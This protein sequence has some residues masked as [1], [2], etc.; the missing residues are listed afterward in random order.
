MALCDDC[1]L[2]HGARQHG[3]HFMPDVRAGETPEGVQVCP[4]HVR[5][6]FEQLDAFEQAVLSAYVSICVSIRQHT[7]ACFSSSWTLLSRLYSQHTSAYASA[8]VSIYVS[9]RQHTSACFSSSWTLFS[10]LYSR[11]NDASSASSRH[12][13][14]YV[15]I[16]QHTSACFNA[17]VM[18]QA[19]RAVGIRQHT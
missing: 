4:A 14:A 8:Y 13:S 18:M 19:A 2:P 15:S 12:T 10:R 1:F 11:R 7:S 5:L 16:R 9:I 17:S 3:C 6:L